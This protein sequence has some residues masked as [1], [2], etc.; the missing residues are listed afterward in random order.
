MKRIM[1]AIWRILDQTLY[2]KRAERGLANMLEITKHNGPMISIETTTICNARCTFCAYPKIP[3]S[4]DIMSMELFEKICAELREG[5]L[6][7]SPFMSDPLTDPLLFDRLKLQDK[8]PRIKLHLFTNGIRLVKLSDL[9][10]ITLLSR[11]EYINISIGGPTRLDYKTMFGVD[12]FDDVILGL[13]RL[14]RIRKK[15]NSRCGLMLHVRTN[16]KSEIN[17]KWVNGFRKL[18]YQ[19]DDVLDTFANWGGVIK[20]EHIPAGAKLIETDNSDKRNPCVFALIEQSILPDG[21][22][23]GCACMDGEGSVITGDI[24]KNTMREVWESKEAIAFRDSFSRGQVT[25]LCST[26]SYYT[27]AHEFFRQSKYAD[28]KLSQNAWHA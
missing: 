27:D 3:R 17:D 4:K 2:K 12:K 19:C 1:R 15:I 8:Y 18:G 6:G 14:A 24:T 10:I 16:K 9:E 25:K 21:R 11:L 7:F 5:Y 26:C 13:V 22:V 23:S 28:F 20:P